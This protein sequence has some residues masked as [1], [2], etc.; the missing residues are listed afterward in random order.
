[1]GENRNRTSEDINKKHIKSPT[2]SEESLLEILDIFL[3]KNN[4][5]INWQLEFY[6]S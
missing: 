6:F 5:S 3:F 1:M 4:F 2:K